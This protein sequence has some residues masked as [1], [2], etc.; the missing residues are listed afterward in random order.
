MEPD[1][2]AITGLDANFLGDDATRIV[3]G[4]LL[5]QPASVRF[6]PVSWT[7]DY[8][9]GDSRTSSTPGATWAQLGLREFDPTSTSHAFDAPGVYTVQLTVSYSAAYSFGGGGWVPV[10]GSVAA[11]AAPITVVV[12]DADTVLVEHPCTVD[13]DGP[14]C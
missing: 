9:D 7:W 2:W 1:G 5:G 10:T 8:G 6:A 12:G 14:G 11:P 13:R 4:A 3:D